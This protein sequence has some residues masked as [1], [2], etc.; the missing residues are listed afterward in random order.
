MRIFKHWV[1]FI[2]S[3]PPHF[4]QCAVNLWDVV[5]QRENPV[6][7]NVFILALL[8][9]RGHVRSRYFCEVFEC[10]MLKL[11]CDQ[12]RVCEFSRV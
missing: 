2:F 6:I 10:T 3:P 8:F 11:A 5:R 12:G 9:M 1:N 7:L 4:F